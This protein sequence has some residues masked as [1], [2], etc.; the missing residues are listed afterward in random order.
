MPTALSLR[1]RPGL[2]IRAAIGPAPGYGK[3]A[4]PAR[5]VATHR[6]R[7]IRTH[8]GRR[9]C[10]A[11]S[12][13]AAILAVTGMI[14]IVALPPDLPHF[15]WTRLRS[16]DRPSVL[17]RVHRTTLHAMRI[18]ITHTIPLSILGIKRVNKKQPFRPALTEKT[19]WSALCDA[20]MPQ[21]AR[22]AATAPRKRKR[23]DIAAAAPAIRKKPR[24]PR[25]SI[26]KN[27]TFSGPV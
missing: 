19:S 1:S 20:A 4:Y 23:R 7:H 14:L 15:T 21:I 5:V 2:A 8:P 25:R 22:L 17:V 6:A 24:Q 16:M 18:G 11:Q 13:R 9:S 27:G 10:G 3:P 12:G 26:G